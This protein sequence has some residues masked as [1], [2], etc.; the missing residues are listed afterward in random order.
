[1]ANRLNKSHH[2]RNI[3]VELTNLDVN[4]ESEDK[5]LEVKDPIDL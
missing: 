5:E 4:T 3:L 1:M 2:T